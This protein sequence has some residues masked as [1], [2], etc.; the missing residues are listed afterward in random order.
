MDI[1]NRQLDITLM[2]EQ[3]DAEL[4][5]KTGSNLTTIISLE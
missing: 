4:E 2:L 3:L 1:T 5:L